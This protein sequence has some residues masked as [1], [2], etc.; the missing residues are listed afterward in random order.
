MLSVEVPRVPTSIPPILPPQTV[1]EIM[2]EVESIEGGA[3]ALI[4]A[5]LFFAGIR[6]EGEIERI[7]EKVSAGNGQ[8][9]FEKPHGKIELG[10]NISK[11][12]HPRWIPIEPNLRAWL[13]RYHPTP[14]HFDLSLYA[15]KG[16]E[17]RKKFRIPQDGCRHNFVSY[18]SAKYGEEASNKAAG[19]S[20]SIAHRHYLNL[21]FSLQDQDTYWSILPTR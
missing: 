14:E 8:E 20:N 16:K 9:I 17:I 19:H 3:L 5:L 15:E 10:P 11:T 7:A 4:Y 2:A 21:G 1:Q 13:S 18:F 6:P 12:H